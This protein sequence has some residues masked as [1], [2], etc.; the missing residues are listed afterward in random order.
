[1]KMKQTLKRILAVGMSTLML[2]SLVAPA[3]AAYTTYGEVTDPTVVTN[4]E[5]RSLTFHDIYDGQMENRPDTSDPVTLYKDAL[6]SNGIFQDWVSLAYN[7]F[8]SQPNSYWWSSW[9]SIYGSKDADIDFVDYMLNKQSRTIEEE[10]LMNENVAGYVSTGLSVGK[11]L[12]DVQQKACDAIASLPNRK[13]TGDDFMERHSI[14][15]LT[16][17]AQNV[18]YSTVT[19]FDRYGRSEQIGYDSFTIAFYDF[20]LHVLSNEDQLA[21]EVTTS[22]STPEDGFITLTENTGAED[23]VSFSTLTNTVE[24]TLSSSITNSETYTF[25]QS[26]GVDVSFS[27]KVGLGGGDGGDAVEEEEDNLLTGSNPLRGGTSVGIDIAAKLT[28]SEAMSTATTE[29]T[30]ITEITEKSNTVAST[31]PAHTRAMANQSIANTTVKTVYDCP[32]GITYKV[33]IFSMCG[34]CY[35]DNAAV[36]QFDTAGYEQRTFATFFGEP[37]DACSAADAVENLYQRA[38]KHKDDSGFDQTAGLVRGTRDD[39]SSWLSDGLDWDT[40]VDQG[41]PTSSITGLKG[42][43]DLIETL[44][45]NY[46]M[47]LTGGATTIT[48]RSITTEMSDPQPLYPIASIAT[49]LDPNEDYDLTV[50]DSVTITSHQVKAYDASGVA[51]YGF[52]PSTGTWKLVNADGS[53]TNADGSAVT[54]EAVTLSVNANTGAQILTAAAPGTA[55]M[56]YFI[57]ENTY[58]TADGVLSSNASVDSPVYTVQVTEEESEPFTGTITVEGSV[59]AIV[60]ETMNLN[61]DAGLVVTAKD[62]TDKEVDLQVSWESQELASKGISVDADGTMTITQAGTFHVRAYADGVYSDWVEVVAT[63]AEDL[64]QF[65]CYHPFTDVAHA[66]WYEAAVEYVYQNDVMNGVKSDLFQPNKTVTRAQVAQVLYNMAGS[67]FV[68]SE[69]PFADVSEDDWYAKAVSWAAANGLTKGK[70]A[71]QFDPN[72][73]VTREQLVTFICRYAD[74]A[75]LELPSGTVDLTQY[76]DA[77]QISSWAKDFVVRALE[78]G[79]I[80]GKSADTLAPQGTATRAQMAQ[81]LMNLLAE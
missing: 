44:D 63:E 52:A 25:G 2:T 42:G 28:F 79:V 18:L 73:S 35:D 75:G 36:Q 68:V 9:D 5:G 57:P 54:S 61:T 64:I 17:T 22:T 1:M 38:V 74:W 39:G 56:K 76:Q 26:I 21:G 24:E 40:I 49:N 53:E 72:A 31:V 16:D 81:I 11:S 10:G 60:G 15:E 27:K 7:I 34:T 58:K 55:Y 51:Y 3:M 4:D 46:P 32:V 47:S 62:T 70:S 48:Q 80:Q 23:V 43:S 50:G 13:L 77:G 67:P 37:T 30:S 29:T 8:E 12:K 66:S 41:A 33:A 78:A 14:P 45:S 71:D 19:T 20:Q 69:N 6:L 59:D 65:I